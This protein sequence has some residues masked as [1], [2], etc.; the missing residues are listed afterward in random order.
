MRYYTGD[1]PAEDI[2]LDPARNEEP[3]VLTPFTAADCEVEL[4]TFEGDLVI[5]EFGLTF[6]TDQVVLE[7]PSTTVLDEPGLYT[8]AVTLVGTDVRERLAPVP[9]VV[10]EEDGWHTLDS[11]NDEWSDSRSVDDARLFQLLELARQQVV[12]YAPALAEGARPPI[13]Y[14]EG[15]RM[16]ARN[17]LNSARAEAGEDGEFVLRPFPLDWMVKQILRPKSGVPVVG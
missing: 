16:Q 14:R 17:I 10:Q 8:L 9:I 5:A 15:Q 6:D 12:A 11:A 7:W 3:I 2:V 4:R 1:I 13:N